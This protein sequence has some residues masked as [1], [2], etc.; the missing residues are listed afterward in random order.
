M[1]NQLSPDLDVTACDARINTSPT[2]HIPQHLNAHMGD[3]RCMYS[4]TGIV[5]LK[6][7]ET[8]HSLLN[9][10]LKRCGITG[11]LHRLPTQHLADVV[12]QVTPRLV[13]KPILNLSFDSTLG[14]MMRH[15]TV[16]F[17]SSSPY[18]PATLIGAPFLGCSTD[19]ICAV[20]IASKWIFFYLHLIQMDIYQ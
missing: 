17:R 15:R 18:S 7:I 13:L 2:Q 1:K 4:H 10:R 16:C 5:P 6:P 12:K 20:I 11:F 19:L 14:I 8:V 3:F 9:Q